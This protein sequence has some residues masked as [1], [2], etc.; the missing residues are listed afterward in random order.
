MPHSV[1]L[2]PPDEHSDDSCTVQILRSVGRWSQGVPAEKSIQNA[3]IWA[4]TNAQHFVYIEQQFFIT[5]TSSHDPVVSNTIGEAIF[6]RIC[7]AVDEKAIFRIMIVLPAWPSNEGDV[8]LYAC[9]R[10][11]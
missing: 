4:I 5:A 7:R 2:L 1:Q 8:S 11:T 10:L 6:N 3:W 9:S